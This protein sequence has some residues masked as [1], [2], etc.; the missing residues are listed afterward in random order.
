M[1]WNLPL[2]A[3]VRALSDS[4][5]RDDSATD[6]LTLVGGHAALAA[7]RDVVP[8]LVAQD[9][10]IRLTVQAM[11]V[12]IEDVLPSDRWTLIVRKDA[13]VA[14]LGFQCSVGEDAVLFLST[15][16]L[17]LWSRRQLALHQGYRWSDR[18]TIL[19]MGLGHAVRGP[20]LRC[21]GLGGDLPEFDSDST[22]INGKVVAALVQIPTEVLSRQVGQSTLTGGDLD[23]AEFS[24]LRM[25]AERDAAQ[26]LSNEVL[27]RP[28]GSEVLLRG[29]RRVCM[30]MDVPSAAPTWQHLE[31]LQEAVAWCFAEHRDARHALLVDRLALD[32]S[33]G[34]SF[35]SYLR[36]DLPAALQDA[37][38]R[39]GLVVIEKKDAAIKEARD[40]LKE[41]R[42]Q[43]DAYASKVR[44]LTATFLRDL[45]AALLLIG[46][47]LM[48]RMNSGGLAK[49]I[50]AA[51]VD[52]FFKVLAA[53]FVLSGVLQISSHWRDL[54]LTTIELERWWRLT[55]TS[56][57]GKE[58]N[59]IL[60]EVIKP[61]RCTFYAVVAVVAFF[62]VFIATAL[63][64]WR[65][66]LEAMLGP[67]VAL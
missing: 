22:H 3:L 4:C 43:A 37:R 50:D 33:E 18:L 11:P 16:G 38:D 35:I 34:A 17:D 61:R 23:A 65:V 8:A 53:Y 47:G 25:W 1:N 9:V 14:A 67:H 59:R 2:L 48:G 15:A 28:G 46:L 21:A 24:C 19:V 55:R 58:V 5:E 27:Y 66:L 44:D 6:T 31:V 10:F 57:A 42:V 56:L 49:I 41:V 52:V 62:N 32:A 40:I 29:G 13:L 36:S 30:L 63:W 45:L 64:N 60:R 51:P 12:E 7:L 20:K 39:Y 54:H 26:L